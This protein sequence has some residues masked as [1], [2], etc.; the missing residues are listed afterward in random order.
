MIDARVLK[1][2][3]A[4]NDYLASEVRGT[5]S[6]HG[7]MCFNVMGG[8]GAGKTSLIERTLAEMKGEF[9][10]GVITGD[11]FSAF[12]GEKI[13]ALGVPVVQINT[14]TCAHLTAN[15]IREV[16]DSFDLDSLD[17]LFIENIGNLM[18]PSGFDLGEDYRIAVLSM[19]EGDDK[20]EKYPKMF[21]VAGAV[22]LTKLDLAEYTDFNLSNAEAKLQV[23]SPDTLIFKTSAKTGVGL[24]DFTS[25]IRELI[26]EAKKMGV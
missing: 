19:P 16:L 3:D 8:P 5:L 9:R 26:T 18:C 2:M 10:F 6:D 24:T 12:D 21:R 1:A 25:W 15:M 13:D 14:E 11:V 17:C 23:L 20:V 4:E 7:I 22:V